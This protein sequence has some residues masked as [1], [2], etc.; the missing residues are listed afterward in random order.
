[1]WSASHTPPDLIVR[2]LVE[3]PSLTSLNVRKTAR[4][5]AAGF[6]ELFGASTLDRLASLDLRGCAP[7]ADAIIQLA[8]GSP[9]L[10]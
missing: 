3:I 1:M 2:A 5:T 8:A 10:T 9:H 7:S 4:V 6:E